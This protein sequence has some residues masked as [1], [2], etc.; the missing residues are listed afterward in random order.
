MKKI[1][2]VMLV[3]VMCLKEMFQMI[4]TMNWRPLNECLI[5]R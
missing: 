3:A 2:K 4:L 5:R 1:R